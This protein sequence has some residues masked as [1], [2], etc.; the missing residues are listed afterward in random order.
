FAA[1]GM[2]GAR[3]DQ[4]ARRAKAN[5][6]L[7]YYYFGSKDDLYTAALEATYAEIRALERELDLSALPPR[8]A[9]IRLI[10]FSLEYLDEHREFIRMLADENAH[11]A[12]H[13]LGS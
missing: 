12:R 10:D 5:K 11:G 1:K 13:V 3:V 2:E 9:M 4:I 7:V 8:E 6:Q